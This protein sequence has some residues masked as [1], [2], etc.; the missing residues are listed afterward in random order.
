M[1]AFTPR[2]GAQL[3]LRHRQQ[4]RF[5][6][7]LE[8]MMYCSAI[9]IIFWLAQQ[10]NY[11]ETHNM[12]HVVPT[13]PSSPPMTS[14]EV[15][16]VS[17]TKSNKYAVT[18][19]EIDESMEESTTNRKVEAAAAAN[20]EGRASKK[21]D[22][23]V[24]N[25]E[26]GHGVRVQ[27]RNADVTDV[28]TRDIPNS[29]K[30][31]T[32]MEVKK[33]KKVRNT[34][35]TTTEVETDVKNKEE[36]AKITADDD[37]DVTLDGTDL[38][39]RLL[40]DVNRQSLQQEDKVSSAN[41]IPN[42]LDPNGPQPVILMSL[43]RSGSSSTWQVIG[44]LTGQETKSVEY[45]GSSREESIRFFNKIGPNEGGWWVMKYMCFMQRVF[46]KAGVVGFK[47]KP[48]RSILTM[49]ASVNGLKLIGRL[50]DPKIKVVRLRRNLL[51]V[52]ISRYKHK[53][54][55]EKVP[56]HCTV[57]DQECLDRQLKAGIGVNLPAHKVVRLLKTLTAEENEVDTHLEALGVPRIHVSFDKLYY[58]DD[59]QEWQKI[60]HFL[61]GTK[62]KEL[63]IDKVRS[64]MKHA[65]TSHP[66]HAITIRNYEEIQS[67]LNGTKFEELLHP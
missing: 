56:A 45:T 40:E 48:N 25:E 59:V 50:K 34:V 44:S 21:K 37:V 23:A 12:A 1:S 63:T 28:E 17:M 41:A 35:H 46:P 2:R 38:V 67:L 22:T 31:R 66:S 62:R 14:W 18:S 64:A 10:R 47:W 19:T 43:G 49:D 57:G 11:L 13:P 36:P 60:V 6:L 4:R 39:K 42:C 8:Q 24:A 29:Q 61:I 9:P 53:R 52:L 3:R 65:S 20:G 27:K 54:S 26:T 58:S 32:E 15:D 33:R 7:R 16:K 5:V 51:D 30:E 55:T